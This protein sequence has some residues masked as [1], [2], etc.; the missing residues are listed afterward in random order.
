MKSLLAMCALAGL[1]SSPA[2]AE[3][4][5]RLAPMPG[6]NQRLSG[7]LGKRFNLG[8]AELQRRLEGTTKGSE[9]LAVLVEA[10]ALMWD[11]A[12]SEAFRRSVAKAAGEL[13][14]QSAGWRSVGSLRRGLRGLLA[15]YEVSG[16]KGAL[17]AARR[18]ADWASRNAPAW[19]DRDL[20]PAPLA[21]PACTLFR[22]T[23]ER[24]KLTQGMSAEMDQPQAPRMLRALWEGK[25]LVGA[26]GAPAEETL[27][28]LTG[29]VELYRLTGESGYLK[30]ARQGWE[31]IVA[32][33]R[34]VTGAV[35][36]RGWL[37]E[38]GMLPG[39]PG[40]EVGDASV[41]AE[42][43]RLNRELLYVTGESSYGDEIER[44]LYNHLM[45]LQDGN[46]GA[47]AAHAPLLGRRRYGVAGE[48]SAATGLALA[49]ARGSFW[50]AFE[51]G[52]AIVLYAGG[53]GTCEVRTTSVAKRV[54]IFLETSFPEQG[55]VRLVIGQGGGGRYP[56]Y[57]RAPNWCARYVAVVGGAAVQGRAG[58]WL[59]FE[60]EWKAGER[61]EIQ[62]GM[63]AQWVRGAPTYAGHVAL[64]RGPQVMVLEAQLNPEVKFL[65]RAAPESASEA[66]VAEVPGRS[67]VGQGRQAYSVPGL[68]VTSAANRQVVARAKLVLIPFAEGRE[69]RT[70]LP[71]PGRLV[72]GP[73]A[74]TAFCMEST[75]GDGPVRDS[76]CDERADT[77]RTAR[78]EG[79]DGSWYAVELDRPERVERIV[80]RHGK[81]TGEGGWFDTSRGKPVV[82]IKRSH[83]G[84][85][86][87]VGRLESYPETNGR[88][89]PQLADGQA[90]EVRLTAPVNAVGI[91]VVGH[92]ARQYSSCAELSAY[93]PTNGASAVSSLE[94]TGSR[95]RLAQGK[96]VSNR[97]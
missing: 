56:V 9:E 14:E 93:G 49:L 18:V 41:T 81:V 76:I 22:H 10:G 63:E 36:W 73:V 71:E 25:R 7:L 43:L 77:Y 62:M 72:L 59:R 24:R 74:V 65:H 78:G 39:E 86:E 85:W 32:G 95:T 34:Y 19:W 16:D 87:T 21:G 3:V 82:Q 79:R 29:L 55:E 40:A 17:E 92:A 5:D 50:G 70:W 42:W 35:G 96:R 45:A 13:I 30:A 44:T 38:D 23:G 60:R 89:A 61:I 83:D 48:R 46:S 28:S 37:R 66:R 80:Y 12:G 58:Q 27:A 94:W 52:P 97:P 2:V 53:E 26:G 47:W 33:H 4:R 31:Q 67:N 51:D 57:L 64:Q 11:W 90:F 54:R 69:Y 91:R 20:G 84:A 6:A 15:Y 88:E 1:C 75:S 8:V 68:V